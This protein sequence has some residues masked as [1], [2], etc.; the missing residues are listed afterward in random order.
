MAVDAVGAL[1]NVKHDIPIICIDS[2]GAEI[3]C[4]NSF[5]SRGG[6]LVKPST[7]GVVRGEGMNI[8]Q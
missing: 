8:E 7:L 4:P 3:T 2:C 1:R 6:G 5:P